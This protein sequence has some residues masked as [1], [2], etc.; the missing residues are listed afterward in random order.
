MPRRGGGALS[1]YVELLQSINLGDE[2]AERDPALEKTFIATA[3]FHELLSDR[4]DVVTGVKGSGKS[5][6]FLR[7][8]D[9]P[10]Q[11][12]VMLPA[13]QVR[14]G[15]VVYETASPW[16]PAEP[17]EAHL[18]D[19]WTLH[20]AL[21]TAAKVSTI[22]HAY[23]SH[24]SGLLQ[25]WGVE[26]PSANDPNATWVASSR[27]MAQ[28]G[29]D[30][31]GT[32]DGLLKDAAERLERANTSL[33]LMYDRL[34]DVFSTSADL[35]RTVLR[36][37]LLAHI[38]IAR[39]GPNLKTKLFLRNDLL[40]RV[41]HEA[42]LRNL[43]KVQILRLN[44]NARDMCQ[45]IAKRLLL[46]R[47]IREYSRTA[48]VSIQRDDGLERVM[49]ALF[50]ARS[51]DSRRSRTF[52]DRYGQIFMN[53][54]D[55]SGKYSPRNVLAYLRLALF[56]QRRIAEREG[57][58]DPARPLLSSKALDSAWFELGEQR[59]RSYVFAEF[60][61]LRPFIEQ[62]SDG[63]TDYDS[64]HELKAALF[65]ASLDAQEARVVIDSL[66]Y[67]GLLYEKNGGFGVGRLYRPPLRLGR[68]RRARPAESGPKE[69]Q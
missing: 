69:T 33:W 10:P 27:L 41:T 55:A 65:D 28:P 53:T 43:D 18:R 62:L 9:S 5:A 22:D 66:K 23:H 2:V 39:F 61:S 46:S 60:P 50:P 29:F 45:L 30:A 6:L 4:C 24:L 1:S 3:D 14:G 48:S 40:D 64:F 32:A 8:L 67:C 15:A 58:I 52:Q 31:R 49:T 34:D 38:H 11:R 68:R 51:I 54:T 21:L 16:D 57:L 19:R 59:L 56:A 42:G 7:A 47:Q 26:S 37:L 17:S 36:A 25:P 20:A 12:V 13:Q 63:P 35:E 44:M